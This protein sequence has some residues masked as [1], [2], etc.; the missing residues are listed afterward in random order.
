MAKI[1]NKNLL[2]RNVLEKLD[3]SQL[4]DRVLQL[5]AHNFQL[6]QIIKKTDNASNNIKTD[7]VKRNFDFTKCQKRHV[8]MKL[9]YLG[10]DYQGFVVQEDFVN[11]IEHYLFAALIKS[12]L[13]ESRETSN[14]HRCGRTDKGVSAFSQVISIDI[15]S[16]LDLVKQ[17]SLIDEIPYCKILNR[18]LPKNIRCICW[19]PVGDMISARFN[20]NWR[21][22]KYFFPR[23]NLNIDLMNEAIQYAIGKHDF[24]N[25]CKMDVGNGVVNF[26]R[27]II[28]A[29]VVCLT[30]ECDL[31]NSAYDMCEFSIKSNAFL[32][33]QIRCIMGILFLV[34]YGQ[35]K[36]EIIKDLLDIEKCPE[37]PQYNIAHY[38]PLNLFYSYYNDVNWNIDKEEIQ[39][40][41]KDLQ[42][43]W[44][45]AAIK[46]TMTRSMLTNLETLLDDKSV[47]LNFQTDCL[48]QGVKRKIYQPLM[49]RQ[50]CESLEKRIEH[51]AKKR[52]LAKTS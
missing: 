44:T 47:S 43:E 22:Y 13:I 1:I 17:G 45:C 34:G 25:L 38:I 14:Y 41:I 7:A 35:E 46:C 48:M 29:Q 16:R 5:E 40:V 4:I 49:Q 28:E 37:K 26:S 31:R 50:R 42:E 21:G 3:K 23:G 39:K 24:R 33:H 2:S 18:L 30:K 51:Y 36:P 19:A 8:F 20:C 27:D 15:R 9:S 52:R 10:W 6:K 11:T 12:C 32:W